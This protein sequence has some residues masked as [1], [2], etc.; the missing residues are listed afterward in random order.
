VNIVNN[1]LQFVIDNPEFVFFGGITLLQIAPIKVDPW[2]KVLQWLGTMLNGDV[3]IQ[4]D[5]LKADM[6]NIKADFDDKITS[7]MRWNIL[8]FS[9][10]CKNG[11]FHTKEE[12]HHVISQLG[13]YE[14]MI[15]TKKIANG[16]MREEARYLKEL[17]QERCQ[18]N[19]FL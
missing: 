4:L 15:E 5:G 11:R 6:E 14:K 16:V 10:S 12:W 9:N 3:Q 17:Y 13:E 18:K 7:D 19:D 1:I 2:V 8:D